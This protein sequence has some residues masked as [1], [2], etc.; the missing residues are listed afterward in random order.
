MP[1]P[2]RLL[3][4]A[5]VHIGMENYGRLDPA[6]GTSSRVRDFLDRLDEMIDYALRGEADLAVFAGDA[7][8]NR[9]PE[10]THQR[11][12][13]ARIKRLAD[14]MPV[15]LVVGNHDTPG[16]AAKASS[17]DIFH[18]LAVP[19]II[20]GGKSGGQ[21]VETRRGPV[22][23]AWMPYPIRNRLLSQP[24]QQGK[25]IEELEAAL[26]ATVIDIVRDLAQA[27]AGQD[28]PRVLAA[29]LSVAE[30]RVGSERLVMLGKDLS[31]PV[32]AL[33]DSA[34]DYIALGHVHRHQELHPSGY[35]PVVYNGSLERIDFGEEQEAKGFCWVELIRGKTKW[36][37]V[38]VAARPFRTLRVD[39]SAGGDP[40]RAVLD[41]VARSDVTGAVV[42]LIVRLRADQT[43]EL[44]EREIQAA[45]G[46]AAH[47]TIWRDVVEDERGRLGGVSPE[48]LAPLELLE[49]YFQG[50]GE[51]TERMVTLLD[52]A[53]EL[54]QDELGESGTVEGAG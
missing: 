36:T 7:F 27:A 37:F 34:W 50:R 24:E 51:S 45:L 18:A 13:A 48:A 5:D 33:E 8:K 12:F 31:L 35:P 11:E 43:A 1:E 40:T 28:M 6:T 25:S 20:V 30:A 23:L 14:A 49:A 9:D 16:M 42:R 26:Q 46:S 52:R 4:F 47:V 39:A 15:L 22:Y 54:M 44:R 2:I 17:V 10:P 29:H 38:P 3:H 21:V 32:S 19:G 41:A 53:A